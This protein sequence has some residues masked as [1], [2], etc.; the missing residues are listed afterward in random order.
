[1]E[2]ADLE[3]RVYENPGTPAVEGWLASSGFGADFTTP[4]PFK[5]ANVSGVKVCA[6]T[7]IAP[8]CSYVV[9]GKGWVYSLTPSSQTG[10]AMIQ[11]FKL[12]P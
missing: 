6:A 7:M 10:E 2:P 1:M 3:I 8:G 9:M 4:E 11:T 5:T 12:L